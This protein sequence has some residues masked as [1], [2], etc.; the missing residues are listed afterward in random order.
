MA[1]IDPNEKRSARV[2]GYVRPS[3]RAFYIAEKRK[4]PNK[5]LSDVICEAL[6]DHAALLIAKQQ[7]GAGVRNS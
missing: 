3:L 6:E 7:I 1:I 5:S 2:G 4:H